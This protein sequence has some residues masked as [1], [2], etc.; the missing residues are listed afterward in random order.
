MPWSELSFDTLFIEIDC[1]FQ[2]IEGFG[3]ASFLTNFSSQDSELRF[4]DCYAVLPYAAASVVCEWPCVLGS[5][6][7][8]AKM[9]LYM[10]TAVSEFC[11][12]RTH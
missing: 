9:L 3:D 6:K 4:G 7:I 1:L 2:K 5:T 10:N 8:S 12:M 11:R